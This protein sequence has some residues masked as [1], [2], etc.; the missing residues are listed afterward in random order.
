MTCHIKGCSTWH[1]ILMVVSHENYTYVLLLV[2]NDEGSQVN[3][4]NF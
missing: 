3:L 1:A 2:K 4:S